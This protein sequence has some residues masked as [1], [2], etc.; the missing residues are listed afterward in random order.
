MPLKKKTDGGKILGGNM[1]RKGGLF[2][3]IVCLVTLAVVQPGQAR[4]VRFVVEQTRPFAGGMSFGDVGPYQRLDGTAY[5][6]VDPHDPLNA[7]VVNLHRAPRNAKGMVEFTAPFFILKPADVSRGNHKLFY[8]I[9]NRGNKQTLGYFNYVPAGPGINDPITVADA[10]DGFL[11][12]LGYTIVD[13]GWQGDVADV[14]GSNVLFP[15]LP[16]AT[17]PDGSPIVEA[18]RIEYSDRT[19][20][21]NG[22]FTL[23]LEGS[24]SFQSYPAA[25]TNT[26]HSI[27]T[28]RDEVSDQG[29]MTPI[30]PDQWAFGT[31]PTGK[32]SLV[33]DPTQIALFG[34]FQADK[35][36]MLIYPAKNPIVM[37]LGYAVTRDIG[38]FLRYENH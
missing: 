21:A 17:Q 7:V 32:D 31:C 24:P 1:A 38:S 28:V 13:A 34:G 25:D 30:A 9:N 4:V 27:L 20:P 22:T 2:A 37:G 3:A 35:L 8:G 15:N 11:M 33:P 18:V 23:P 16:I 26:S 5:M 19:I 10:G 6:E 12:R 14:P 29:P 36:Y